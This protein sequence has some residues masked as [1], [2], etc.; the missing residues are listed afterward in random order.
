MSYRL[1]PRL[2][3]LS[4]FLLTALSA[5]GQAP[6]NL[7]I[8]DIQGVKSTTAATISPYVGQKVTT[9]GVVT[10][11]VLL[12]RSGSAPSIGPLRPNNGS[13]TAPQMSSDSG[14]GSIRRGLRAPTSGNSSMPKLYS[15]VMPSGS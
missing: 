14:T 3:A 9:T 1:F 12:L 8:H 6:P 11:D 13:G 5:F 2:S 15:T 10:V 7:E 4:L